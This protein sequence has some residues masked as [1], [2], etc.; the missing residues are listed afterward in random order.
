MRLDVINLIIDLVVGKLYNLINAQ[1]VH[2]FVCTNLIHM[3][4]LLTIYRVKA[5]FETFFRNKLRV[6][7]DMQMISELLS[8]AH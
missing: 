6:S 4:F 1:Q 5:N 7:V 3:Y 2:V 8:C